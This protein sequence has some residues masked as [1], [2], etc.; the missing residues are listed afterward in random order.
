MSLSILLVDDEAALLKLNHEILTNHGFKVIPAESAEKAL[1]IL[2]HKTVDVLISDIIM[3]GMDGYQ[4]A[5]IVKE[6]YPD[7]K[8]QLASGFTDN[9]NMDMVDESL[10]QNLLSKPFNSQTLLQRIHVLLNE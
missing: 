10:Q 6:K 5:A 9:R 2:E 1:E 8:I 7:I 3:P 4:L